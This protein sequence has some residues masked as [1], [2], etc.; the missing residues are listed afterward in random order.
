MNA[1]MVVFFYNLPSGWCSTGPVMNLLTAL[2]Q[3]LALREDGG[4]VVPVPVRWRRVA[5][6]W[7]EGATKYLGHFPGGTCR[8]PGDTLRSKSGPRAAP[9]TSWLQARARGHTMV[10]RRPAA[11]ATRFV[12]AGRESIFEA[13]R[14]TTRSA[15]AST[16]W[17]VALAES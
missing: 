12:M 16:R 10:R 1:V 13:R 6:R 2:Q 15:W 3:W 4:P 14:W 17:A 7:P 9:R 5:G 11:E 8:A